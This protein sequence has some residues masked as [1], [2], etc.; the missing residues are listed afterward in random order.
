MSS[1]SPSERAQRG[2]TLRRAVNIA[3]LVYFVHAGIRLLVD[4]LV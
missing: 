3:V 4:L 2:L 1:E